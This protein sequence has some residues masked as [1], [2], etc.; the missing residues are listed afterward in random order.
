[1]V[2]VCAVVI[3]NTVIPF[4]KKVAVFVCFCLD[5]IA[6]LSQHTK[7]A[8]YVVKLI[9]GSFQIILD[10]FERGTFTLGI[11]HPGID[12]VGKDG[13]KVIIKPVPAPDF[14]ADIIESKLVVNGLKKKISAFEKGLLSVIQQLVAVKWN[15]DGLVLGLFVVILSFDPGLFLCP[16]HDPIS[17]SSQHIG[18]IF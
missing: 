11:Q 13:I 16:D 5:E 15:Q 12:Q 17:I 2:I 7:G 1:K 14:F 6:L 18:K 4:T 8:V 9:R 3:K 10:R